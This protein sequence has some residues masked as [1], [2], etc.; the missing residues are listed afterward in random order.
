MTDCFISH[1]SQDADLASFVR[2]QL[3]R[4]GIDV[5]LARSS[6]RPGAHWTEEVWSRL[7]SSPL[8]IFLASRAACR[9]AFVQ[10]E[11]GHALGEDKRIVPIIWDIDPGELPGWISRN[12]ALDIRQMG[13]D[14]LK[15]QLDALAGEI[16]ARRTAL[17]F[18]GLAVIAWLLLSNLTK[19]PESETPSPGRMTP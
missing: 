10:Q 2:D 7:R 3:R 17:C 19:S 14:G 8:V 5:F 12:Q 4:Q 6:I 16:I 1:S 13:T 11:L 9:S 15:R 18:A